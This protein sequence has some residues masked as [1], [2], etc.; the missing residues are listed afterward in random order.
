M[1]ACQICGTGTDQRVERRYV[2]TPA[3]RP[4]PANTY[5]VG[6]CDDCFTLDPDVPGVA[7]R[8]A[9]RVL[10]KEQADTALAAQAFEEAGVDVSTVLYDRGNPLGDRGRRGPQRKAWKHVDKAALRTGYTRFL[11]LRVAAASRLD[12]RPM[13]ATAPPSGPA[14]CLLCGIG[15]STHWQSVLT[16][17]LTRGPQMVD[18]HLCAVCAGEYDAVGAMGAPLVEKACLTAHGFEWSDAMR[19]PGLKPWI[20]TGL[21]PRAEA[22]DWVELTP[23]KPDLDP[24]V[25][26]Q[27]EVKE[28]RARVEALES[29]AS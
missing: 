18:G 11:D 19:A 29:E 1:I 26:L 9:L 17:A 25:A 10:G 24:V 16:S 3:G 8:A 4:T 20:A 14:A 5:D 28:L 15:Q 2:Q 23:P 6:T 12:D 21:T 7:V 13:P 22:W 27:I